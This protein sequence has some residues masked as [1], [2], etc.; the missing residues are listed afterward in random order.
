MQEFTDRLKIAIK[1][2]L[3][4]TQVQWMMAGSDRLVKDFPKVPGPDARIAG[5]LILLWPD[6]GMVHTVFM[7]RPDYVGFHGGQISF[8]G[9]KQEPAD[10]NIIMTAFREAS[11]EAGLNTESIEVAGLLTP[12]F[13]PVSNTIVTAVVG[14]SNEPPVFRPDPQE[15]DHL[16]IADLQSFLDPRIIKTK[17]MELR[18]ESYIIRYFGYRDYVI[19]GATAMMLNELIEIFRRDKISPDL[20][21]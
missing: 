15:V 1:R 5:V 6:N 11:E 17:P 8:P 3:P 18:G 2:G 7:Q 20:S 12:L 13:I 9:G 4:G 16:I 19:W 14:C 10:E 21:L